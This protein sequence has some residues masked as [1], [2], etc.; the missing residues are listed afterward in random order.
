MVK[1]AKRTAAAR[2]K[3]DRDQ[4]Y[5]ISDAIRIVKENATAKF[6]ETI[7][8]AVNLGVDPKHADQMVRG[9][10]NLPNGTGRTVRVAVFAR[11]AKAAEAKAAGADI[12]VDIAQAHSL[13]RPVSDLL[14]GASAGAPHAV[15]CADMEPQTIAFASKVRE[16][17]FPVLFTAPEGSPDAADA[18]EL[19]GAWFAAP[20]DRT[21]DLPPAARAAIRSASNPLLA[22]LSYD[23]AMVA[24]ALLTGTDALL[25]GVTFS[26]GLGEFAFRADRLTNREMTITMATKGRVEPIARV[27]GL[28]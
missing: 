16:E 3:V 2:S 1:V 12:V 27:A 13:D 20:S 15:L 14:S 19:D 18:V 7:E 21:G 23:S 5:S 17:G 4:Q 24:P 10:V 28:G 25:G 6:D 11:D 8:V 26:G 22:G 9:V